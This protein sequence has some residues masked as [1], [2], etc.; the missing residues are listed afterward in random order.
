MFFAPSAVL[1]QTIYLLF[2]YPA[3]RSYSVARS[4]VFHAVSTFGGRY[5]SIGHNV[6]LSAD[7]LPSA[8]D[9][10][11]ISIFIP[12]KSKRVISYTLQYIT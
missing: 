3:K 9:E 4:S 11:I 1:G 10:L 6:A 8:I 7:R 12:I 2:V 5:Q